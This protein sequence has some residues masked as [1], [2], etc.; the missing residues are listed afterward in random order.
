[1]ALPEQRKGEWF[2]FSATFIGAFFP[3]VATLSFANIPPFISLGWSTVLAG[4]FF[5]GL[6]LYRKSWGELRNPLLWRY[7]FVI[8]LC[9]GVLLYGLFFTG[10]E[11]T[12][13][14]NAAI[15]NLFAVFTS[16]L[17]FNAWRREPISFEYKI[18]ASLMVLGALVVLAPGFS[19]I[20][21]GD[22]IVLAAM[23]FAPP[24]NFYQQ[25]AR[26]IASSETVMFLRSLL[27]APLLF[28][29]AYFIGERA[30]LADITAAMPFLFINGVIILGVSKLFW[31]EGI[32]RTLVTK[33]EAFNTA[34]PFITLLFAFLLL[35]QSPTPWQL[36]SLAPLVLGVLLLTDQLSLG[37]GKRAK[38]A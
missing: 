31:I 36:L 30:S 3:I 19:H 2:I 21:G 24:G 34:G 26:N 38:L 1:M 32:H 37:R 29:L 13:P 5:A 27:S 16:F 4:L 33:A 23:F 22:L 35:Q 12:T 9:I 28:V 20:N 10:L 17:F 25:K 8:A 11:K 14:G 15:I 7:C 18:G 6:M